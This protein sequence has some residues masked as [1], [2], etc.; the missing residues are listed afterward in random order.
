LNGPSLFIGGD[1]ETTV[2]AIQVFLIGLSIPVLLLGAA[3]EQ[4]RRAEMT[5]R[6]SEE[7]MA[8]AA[9][10]ANIGLWHFDGATRGLW[11][12]EHCRSMLGLNA[13]HPTTTDTILKLV[14]SEDQQAA[15]ASFRAAADAGQHAVSEFRITMPDGIVRW[16]RARAR[17]HRDDEDESVRLSGIFLDITEQKTAESEAAMQRREIAHLMRVS[18]LGEL[19][20]AIA[21]E[22]NQPLAAIHLNAEAALCL[23]ENNSP[24]LAEVRDALQDIV[25]QDDRAGEVIRRLRRLLRKGDLK[26]ELIDLNDLVNSTIDLLHSEMIGRRISVKADLAKI[27]P[28]TMGDPVQLQQV[29]LNLVMNAMDAMA[30]TPVERKLVTVSTRATPTGCI[31]VCVKD[32]GTGITPAGQS[33]LFEPFYSTKEHGLGLGLTI[34]ASIVQAHGGKLTLVNGDGGG[35]VAGVS[36]P[37]QEIL[38]AK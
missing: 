6:E 4:A 17:A 3:I 26:S 8:F 15:I 25:R 37:T 19:S 30:L 18:M 11:M 31:E 12:T 32:G 14:H 27:L 22:I 36:L 33:R 5:T 16:F 13:D 28:P 34:S 35:A 10:S 9:A 24:N 21:H 38:I 2:F 23:L 20:G 1:P 29:L 7:R